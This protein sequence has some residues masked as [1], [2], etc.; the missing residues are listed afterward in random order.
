MFV[1]IVLA[2]LLSD[3]ALAQPTTTGW[4]LLDP[5]VAPSPRASPAMA[6][7]ARYNRTILYG[8]ITEI[9][10]PGVGQ[11]WEYDAQANLWTLRN[12][13]TA[14]PGQYD[15]SMVYDS[16]A[17]RIIL[18]GGD[19]YGGA[20]LDQTWAY[21]YANDTWTNLNPPTAPPGRNTFGMVY[22]SRADRII[23]FGGYAST[24]GTQ[25]F[26]DTW[27]YDYWNNTWTDTSP[28]SGPSPRS[29]LTMAYDAS[30]DVTIMYG[31]IGLYGDLTDTWAF[32]YG[33]DTW[34]QLT[35]SGTPFATRA[36]AMVY[37]ARADRSVLAGGL[38]LGA[39]GTMGTWTLDYSRDNWTL[40][41]LPVL[42][43]CLM[44]AGAA[45]DSGSDLFLLFGGSAIGAAGL[46]NGTWAF[47]L[48]GPAPVNAAE[49]AF[50]VLAAVAAGAAWVAG[51][52][53]IG[54]GSRK[55]R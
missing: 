49:L 40:L 41:R 43:P 25:D 36:S 51:V 19:S 23:I 52:W 26:G 17:D 37:D 45:Y 14:P 35:P 31:G 42:P 50:L 18:F 54:R 16:H 7:D 24:S 48:G 6:Y 39:N 53:F 3:P 27:A 38:C 2:V 20:W 28:S 33:T 55:S 13:P 47:R 4:T 15:A 9:L 10:T 5:R 11:T 1:V 22:D 29:L 8:G 46:Y 30:A 21:D 32:N 44:Q 12:P 34:R